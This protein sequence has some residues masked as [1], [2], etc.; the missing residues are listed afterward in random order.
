[1]NRRD[2]LNIFAI[3]PVQAAAAVAARG[4]HS[5]KFGAVTI[6][7]WQKLHAKGITLDV[8][9][10]GVKVTRDCPFANDETG[11]IHLFKTDKHGQHYV[12]YETGEVASEW[13]TGK[14]EFRRRD[15]QQKPHDRS[16]SLRSSKYETARTGS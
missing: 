10:H 3:A 2:V 4:H 5:E 15:P 16:R 1:M 9:F 13:L 12:D 14:V 6:E 11:E 8:Y 7:R